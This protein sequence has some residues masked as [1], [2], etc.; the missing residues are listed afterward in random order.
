[1]DGALGTGGLLLLERTTI[2][3]KRRIG[4]KFLAFGTKP[5]PCPVIALAKTDNHR[6]NRLALMP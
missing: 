4:Q 2:E 6:F 1:M 5:L 3:A